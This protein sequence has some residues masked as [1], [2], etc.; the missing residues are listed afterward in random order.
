VE[1]GQDCDA[2]VN[3]TRARIIE[4]IGGEAA[5]I[6]VREP[7][8]DPRCPQTSDADVLAFGDVDSLLPVRLNLPATPGTL[9]IDV[10]WLPR[11]LLAD[12]QRFAAEG[13]LPHRLVTSA[14]LQ[15]RNGEAEA[16]H[17]RVRVAIEQPQARAARI[18]GF[19]QMG[20]L[21]VRE[22]GVT[23]DFPAMALFWLHTAFA[24][25]TAALCDAA[26]QLCPNVYTRPFDN[27]R[28]LPEPLREN[29]DAR[30]TGALRLNVDPE[31]L[32][33][34]LR[35]LHGTIARRFPEPSW[36]AAI[37]GTTRAEYV[38]FLDPA[39]LEW[40][41]SVAREMAA[42]GDAVQAAYYLRF[43]AYS[44]ARVPMVHQ[45]A[46]QG[47][48]VSFMRPER[49]MAPALQELCVDIIDPLSAILAAA[50]LTADDVRDALAV[51]TALRVHAVDVAAGRGLM[52]GALQP[53]IPFEKGGDP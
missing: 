47:R 4:M 7:F 50:T 10:I 27:L 32:I 1:P 12:S 49:A 8:I 5:A 28:S 13:L 16:A 9:P 2:I 14:L 35:E 37:R 6:F 34:V 25:A 22:I 43:W 33:P 48:D 39:E 42:R 20:F 24:A 46:Q 11:A 40:R 3:R 29:W 41:I 26:G 19:M 36:P 38:Y 17:R 31:S 51:V 21:A 45:C 52:P 15:D 53:W 23:W 18:A 30:I 44:L